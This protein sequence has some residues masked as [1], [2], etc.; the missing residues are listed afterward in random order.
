MGKYLFS[1]GSQGVFEF[2]KPILLPVFLGIF[3]KLGFNAVI[4][5]KL[6]IFLVSFLTLTFLY[7]SAKEIFN[8]KAGIIASIIL[9]LNPLF[10]LFMYRIYTEMMSVCFILGSVFFMIKFSK[11]DKNYFLVL[12]AL[13]CALAFFSKYPN[14]LLALILNLFLLSICYKKRKISYLFWFNI[15]LLAFLLPFLILNYIYTG[16][17]LYLVNAGQEY[18][19]ENL[20]VLYSFKTFPGIP[21]LFFENTDLLYFKSIFYLFNILLQLMLLGAY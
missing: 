13:F 14:I 10:F 3:W 11:Q 4:A 6:F 16:D 20:G 12:S 2:I 21:K 18:Y 15:I 1:H 8:K 19:K 9:F 5:G 17:A 7:L